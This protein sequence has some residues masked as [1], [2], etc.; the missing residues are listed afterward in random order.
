MNYDI[1]CFNITGDIFDMFLLN[2]VWT[3]T[4]LLYK[5]IFTAEHSVCI[6]SHL[7]LHACLASPYIPLTLES[8]HCLSV[9]IVREARILFEYTSLELSYKGSSC[10]HSA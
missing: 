7:Q 4:E 8:Q 3:V 6:F 5:L 9:S 2:L 1:A 10:L